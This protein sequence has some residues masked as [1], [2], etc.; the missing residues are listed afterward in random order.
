M[1]DGL[2][3][4]KLGFMSNHRTITLSKESQIEMMKGGLRWG[5]QWWTAL[6]SARRRTF[7]IR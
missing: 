4:V 6:A 1:S 2:L 7:P 5:P 3:S